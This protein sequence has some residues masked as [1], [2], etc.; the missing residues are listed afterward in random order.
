MIHGL[1]ERAWRGEGVA[2]A[3]ARAGLT[4]LSWLY[5]A[6]VTVRN[7]AYDAGLFA[8]QSLGAPTVSVG[9][10]TVGG[11]GKTPVAAWLAERIATHGARPGIL[12]RGYGGDEP[13][14]HRVLAPAAIVVAH[15]DRRSAA[16]QAQALGATVFVLDDAFQHRQV[17]RDAD[18]VLVPA[19]GGERHA[20]LPAGPLREP[21]SSLRRATHV[22]V[23]RK[24]ASLDRAQE[25]AAWARRASG[26]ERITVLHLAADTLVHCHDASTRPATSLAG[27]SVLA[28]A[29]IG[30]P[31]A[32]VAQ[33]QASGG[34]VAF[35]G[36]RDHHAFGAADV[37]QLVNRA[38]GTD[39]VVCTLKDA[40]KLGPIWPSTAPPLWYLSQRVHVDAGA[41]LIDQ[42]IRRLT[43]D[44]N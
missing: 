4:P 17:R 5:G 26:L 27:V 39:F 34:R 13:G 2:A 36:F 3:A 35:R 21:V 8:S 28:V 25:V 9:N 33:L 44:P 38:A 10:L 18:I 20:L 40:V 23:S 14:V 31:S 7:R 15:A 16:R 6:T 29:G 37:M 42:L 41:E 1:A 22:V 30:N 12:L 11:T 24:A 19:D 32:F 43:T